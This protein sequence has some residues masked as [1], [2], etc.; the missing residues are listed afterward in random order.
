MIETKEEIETT[1]FIITIPKATISM[2]IKAKIY[3]N[4]EIK[5]A[6]TTIDDAGEIHDG[7]IKGYEWEEDHTVYEIVKDEEK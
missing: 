6:V 5:E 7:M 2:E 3:I 1:P 4:G